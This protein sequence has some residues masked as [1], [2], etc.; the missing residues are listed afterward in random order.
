MLWA[1]MAGRTLLS[2]IDPY[3]WRPA[4][5]MVP[6]PLPAAFIGSLF[7]AV[8]LR[9]AAG[10]LFGLSAGL[11]A[12]GL[13]RFGQGWHLLVFLSA[14]FLLATKSIQWSPLVYAMLLLPALSP[15]WVIKPTIGGAVGCG[16]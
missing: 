10:S 12:F 6:Y 1:L 4:I 8:P 13:T 9:L 5:D 16:I 15:L 3:G 11:L 2:G 7:A 14:P